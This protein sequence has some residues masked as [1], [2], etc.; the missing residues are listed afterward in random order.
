M[1]GKRVS[2]VASE[3]AERAPP[4]AQSVPFP[5]VAAGS[6]PVMV[7]VLGVD[8]ALSL[9][10]SPSTKVRRGCGRFRH[11]GPW[12]WLLAAGVGVGLRR[13]TEETELVVARWSQA[14]RGDVRGVRGDDRSVDACGFVWGV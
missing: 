10:S 13:P 4:V 11:A 14:L 1:K 5:D 2:A 8:P 12:G 7:V 6:M 3:A 9:D